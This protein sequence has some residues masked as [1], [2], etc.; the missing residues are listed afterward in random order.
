MPTPRPSSALLT[1]A[2]ALVTT[3][4]PGLET[5]IA[6]S[7]VILPPVAA[8][9][10]FV[11]TSREVAWQ[12]MLVG[13]ACGT[14]TMAE[15]GAWL[16]GHCVDCYAA[17]AQSGALVLAAIVAV[18]LLSGTAALRRRGNIARR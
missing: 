11:R 14:P 8:L 1:G 5:A 9:E 13:G 16:F 12:A 15:R 4:A 17:A 18:D 10:A 3:P 6:W 2:H 7:A